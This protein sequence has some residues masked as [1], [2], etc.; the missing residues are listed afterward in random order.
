ME[1]ET[2]A[3]AVCGLGATARDYISTVE[4]VLAANL[5]LG[6]IPDISLD[7]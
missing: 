2:W 3:H 6:T 7:L 5:Y 4:S 1:M